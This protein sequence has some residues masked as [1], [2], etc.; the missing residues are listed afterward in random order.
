MVGIWIIKAS[1]PETEMDLVVQSRRMK[2]FYFFLLIFAITILGCESNKELKVFFYP[3]KCSIA[4]SDSNY[5]FQELRF[6]YNKIKIDSLRLNIFE[7]KE[8]FNSSAEPMLFYCSHK[9]VIFLDVN[10]V[11]EE[12]SNLVYNFELDVSGEDW[13]KDSVELIL[14]IE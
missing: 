2:N 6:G 7:F 11:G 9:E 4:I 13:N 5:Y 1:L 14:A 8:S 12:D 3:K 10:V